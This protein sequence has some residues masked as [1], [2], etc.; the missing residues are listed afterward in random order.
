MAVKSVFYSVVGIIIGLAAV[1]YGVY[2]WQQGDIDK[3]QKQ[4]KDTGAQLESIKNQ[5]QE[6]V[7]TSKKGLRL[8]VYTP[9]SNQQVAS[10]LVILGEVPGNW[11]FEA[12]FPVLLKNSDGTIIAKTNA[13]LLG[14]WMTDKL[15]PFTARFAFTS[16]ASGQGSLV[17]QKDN[18]SGL[19][20]ND[21][22][23]SIP[24]KF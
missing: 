14:D 10:P 17:L 13:E 16:A 15:V 3:L 4:V 1:G 2:V 9:S 22:E 21:D 23:V 18:P 6:M 12:S 5:K 7:Y 11:S 24:I 19:A 20:E 8:K